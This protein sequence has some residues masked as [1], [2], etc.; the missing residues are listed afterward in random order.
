[1]PIQL[2]LG[3]VVQAKG[4]SGKASGY[5]SLMRKLSL[6]LVVSGPLWLEMGLLL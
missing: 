3:T 5:R 4:Q 1:M 2:A 6:S